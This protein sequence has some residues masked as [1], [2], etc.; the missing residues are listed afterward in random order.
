MCLALDQL[1]ETK[2]CAKW[3]DRPII[4]TVDGYDWIFSDE[5]G[6]AVQKSMG[7]FSWNAEEVL[8]IAK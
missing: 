1:V 6:V 4:D 7:R 8:N 3:V 2:I 5:C